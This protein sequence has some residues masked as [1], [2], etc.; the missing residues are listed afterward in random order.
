[1]R[2]NLGSGKK[3]MEGYINCDISEKSNPDLIVD[4][5]KELPFEEDSIDEIFMDNV[6]EHTKNRLK[7][8]DNLYKVCKNGAIIKIIVPY[9]A[10]VNSVA[11][12]D[13][14]GRFGY[15]T[16]DTLDKSKEKSNWWGEE[17]NFKIIK[18]EL[19]FS[20]R[21]KIIPFLFNKS[22]KFKQLYEDYL[23]NIFP[24]RQLEVW[25]EVRK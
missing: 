16:F 13:H 12:L 18:K 21:A 17:T 1:M 15:R 24:A 4:I 2:L 5:E 23:A 10:H 22:N 8:L 9:F 20:K 7:V 11:C 25:L 14:Y 19:R 6:L 3:R